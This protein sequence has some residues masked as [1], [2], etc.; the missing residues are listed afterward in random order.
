MLSS[1]IPIHRY[2][3]QSLHPSIDIQKHPPPDL[4]KCT[5]F[6]P[7]VSKSSLTLYPGLP[8]SDT[9]RE[10]TIRKLPFYHKRNYFHAPHPSPISPSPF[11]SPCPLPSLALSFLLHI[12]APQPQPFGLRQGHRLLAHQAPTSKHSPQLV[13]FSF[14]KSFIILPNHTSHSSWL[15]P[16]TSLNT[17]SK[18]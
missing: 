5:P 15:L 18:L 2:R 9:A 1:Y 13:P 17:C 11:L 12:F 4:P 8:S 10:A 7:S 14:T 3:V 6:Q 16:L